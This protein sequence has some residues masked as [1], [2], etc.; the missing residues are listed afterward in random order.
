[1][2]TDVRAH[3]PPHQ[4]HHYHTEGGL[5]LIIGLVAVIIL[6]VLFFLY[7]LPALRTDRVGADTNDNSI[8]PENRIEIKTQ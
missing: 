1:M 5:G 7:A 4:E 3:N 6:V 8:V 2:T